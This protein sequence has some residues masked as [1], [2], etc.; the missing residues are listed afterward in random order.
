MD[1]SRWSH[2]ERVYDAALACDPAARDAF[3]S[4]ACGGDNGLRQE[5]ESL[6]RYEASADGFLERSALHETAKLL[7]AR[8]AAPPPLPRVSGYTIRKLIGEGGMGLVYLADQ[9]EPLRRRVAL[10]LVKPGLGSQSVAR[11]EAERQALAQMDH[12]NISAVYDAGTSDDGRPYFVMEF[13]AGLPITEYCDRHRLSTRERLDLFAQVCSAVQHAHQKGVIHRDL[14]PSNVLVSE[15]DA[16]HVAKVIDFGTAKAT[17]RPMSTRSGAT[18]HGTMIGTLEY[19]SPEQAALSTDVDTRADV[20]SLGVVLYELL[21]GALPFDTRTLRAAGYDEMRRVI[22]ESEPPRPSERLTGLGA[23]AVTIAASRRTD[24]AP[25]ARDLTGDLDWIILR[26][27]EKDRERRYATVAAFAED[28]ERFLAHKPVEARSPSTS[29]RIGKFVRRHR[30][31]VAASAALAI[32]LTGLAII[33]TGYWRAEGA[34]AAAD[35]ERVTAIADRTAADEQR[36]AAEELRLA[37]E[38]ASAAAVA[39]RKEADAERTKADAERAKADAQ[40]SVAEQQRLEAEAMRQQAERA[41]AEATEQRRA[42]ISASAELERLR[43]LEADRARVAVLD[44]DYRTYLAAIA[45]A[46]GELRA[47]V[48]AA[49]RQRLLAIPEV[50]RE[51]EWHHLFLRTDPSV[52]TMSSPVRCGREA[53]AATPG[54]NVLTRAT[55]GERI[56]HR[57]CGTLVAWDAAGFQPAAEQRYPD[58]TLLA[59]NAAGHVVMAP[60][61]EGPPTVR[62]IDVKPSAPVVTLGP[63][64]GP[65]RCAAISPDGALIVLGMASDSPLN[66]DSSADIFEVWDARSKRV[67]SRFNPGPPAAASPTGAAAASCIAAFSPDTRLIATSGRTVAVWSRDG[68]GILILDRIPAGSVSQPIAFSP[69][70]RRLAVGRPTGSVDLVDLVTAGGPIRRLEGRPVVPLPAVDGDRSAL[71]RTS[72]RQEVLSLAFRSDG[73]RI[74]TGTSTTV[75]IWDVAEGLLKA[76]LPGHAAPVTGAAFVGDGSFIL[77]AD[78]DGR[79]RVWPGEASSGNRQVTAEASSGFQPKPARTGKV[80]SADGTT[81]AILAPGPGDPRGFVTIWSGDESRQLGRLPAADVT[82]IALSPNGK[83]LVSVS[84]SEEVLVWDTERLQVVLTLQ[85]SEG[86]SGGVAFS[87]DGRIVA[88][89]TSGGLTVW[90][91]QP[92]ACRFCPGG[93]RD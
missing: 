60:R 59:V 85:D 19:M 89:R 71:I 35:R 17:A 24:V 7:T 75:S 50:R 10:K 80:T 27:L 39:G 34:R 78:S 82:A 51:W 76:A 49:A 22:R 41:S 91:S 33:T 93:R 2:V 58:G 20:Y 36:R 16:R 30:G 84:Q 72:Q 57:R 90:E 55:R 74:V 42:A 5:V 12:P 54:D 15:H 23:D 3:L 68:S 81:V 25:L 45:A 40:R 87:V 77:S 79:L 69:D 26:A 29:Y 9:E 32:L 61:A 43:R 14:K 18:E 31:G 63:L 52:S 86:H 56:L 47:N 92:P 37:A 11:F 88:G 67:L 44:A 28:I 53:D 73:A 1:P 70:G 6:L 38:R 8:E 66:R 48:T 64:K 83:R 62:V 13:V 4:Q 46:E 21:V 65:P